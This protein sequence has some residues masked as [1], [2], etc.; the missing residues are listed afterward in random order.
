MPARRDLSARAKGR[1]TKAFTIA[2]IAAEMESTAVPALLCTE[3][4]GP[5]LSLT[6][7]NPLPAE[8]MARKEFVQT[9]S[10]N[11]AKYGGTGSVEP[12]ARA[13][14]TG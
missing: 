14:A 6:G 7:C 12:P 11:Q 2:D 4:P 13:G 10:S 5:R 1:R 8:W 3:P 9:S